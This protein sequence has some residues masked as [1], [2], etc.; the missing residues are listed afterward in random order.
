VKVA[1]SSLSDLAND[2]ATSA[3][4]V[5]EHLTELDSAVGRLAESWQGEAEQAKILR[6]GF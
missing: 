6:I 2:L 5:E 3:D 4:R 1:F